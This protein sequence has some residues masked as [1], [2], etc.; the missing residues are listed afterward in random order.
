MT[1]KPVVMLSILRVRPSAVCFATEGLC[2]LALTLGLRLERLL[3]VL[4]VNACFCPLLP[5]HLRPLRAVH[6]YEL[7][8]RWPTGEGEEPRALGDVCTSGLGPHLRLLRGFLGF[9]HRLCF[10]SLHFEF[11]L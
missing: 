8:F 1:G 7:R 4:G 11:L 6:L 9:L 10:L 2:R 3:E 5:G